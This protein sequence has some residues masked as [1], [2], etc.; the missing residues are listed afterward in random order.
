MYYEP[1]WIASLQNHR[2]ALRQLSVLRFRH[3]V[4]AEHG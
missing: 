3:S 1:G 2:T 4:G